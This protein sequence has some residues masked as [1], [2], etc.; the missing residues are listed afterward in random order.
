MFS[1]ITPILKIQK[2][3]VFKS[4]LFAM[5]NTSES[6]LVMKNWWFSKGSNNSD[7]ENNLEKREG[8]V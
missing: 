5:N 4:F 2:A 6:S 1:G 7:F 8:L 3:Q